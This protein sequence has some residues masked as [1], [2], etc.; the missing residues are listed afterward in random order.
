MKFM[1]LKRFASTVMAGVLT[2]SLAVPAFAAD[3]QPENSTVV[4]ATYAEI[5]IAVEVPTTGT[6]QINPYGLPVTVT[7][8]DEK[9]VDLVGQKITTQ[10]L[11]IKN[12]GTTDLDVGATLAVTPK[13]EVTINTSKNTDKQIK[14]DLEVVG[15]D[16]T[17]LAIA[18]TSTK[19]EDMLIDKFAAPATWTNAK[20]LAAP[21]ATTVNTA[22]AAPAE[23]DADDPLATLGAATVKGEI[24]TYAKNSIALFR[25]TGDLSQSPKTIGANPTDNPWEAA[26]GF[27]ATIVFKFAPAVARYTVTKGTLTGNDDQGDISIDKTNAE[28]G[29][30]VTITVT[31][32]N[33]NSN[34]AIT[35]T[36]ADGDTVTV[37]AGASNTYTFTMPAKNVTVDATFTA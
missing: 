29:A 24:I 2:L 25:L 31:P 27:T 28:A 15:L 12:Q 26:D 11:S 10:P 17:T 13:G 9:T 1:N 21:A 18:S 32:D 22:P 8:S 37:T 20:T 23:S 34:V 30:T 6:A 36:D 19:L 5:P 33:T 16:D 3:T 14:V 35:V 7:K 4:T